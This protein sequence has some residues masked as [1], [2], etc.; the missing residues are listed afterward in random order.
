MASRQERGAT[1]R[2]MQGGVYIVT[3][4]ASGKKFIGTSKDVTKEG[5]IHLARLYNF[6]H[7]NQDLQT[8]YQQD[9][10]L[11]VTTEVWPSP[12]ASERRW[13]E[14]VTEAMAQGIL[15]NKHVQR[16]LDKIPPKEN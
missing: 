15:L 14:L 4:V 16:R 10:R 9:K 6:D 3:H 12:E 13:A 5:R 2:P 7:S 1:Q 11:E 8:L